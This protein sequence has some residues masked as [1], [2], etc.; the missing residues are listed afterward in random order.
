MEKV[1]LGEHSFVILGI[2]VERGKKS[3]TKNYLLDTVWRKQCLNF[4]SSILNDA[5]PSRASCTSWSIS[6]INWFSWSWV[7]DDILQCFSCDSDIDLNKKNVEIKPR[8]HMQSNN[9]NIFVWWELYSQVFKIMFSIANSE[10]QSVREGSGAK[11]DITFRS[12][13]NNTTSKRIF[14]YS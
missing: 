14:L 4:S 6:S 1:V 7:D 3:T 13:L 2:I 5:M 10:A 8:A 11:D 12:R 9:L